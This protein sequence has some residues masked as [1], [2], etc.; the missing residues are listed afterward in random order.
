MQSL[1]RVAMHERVCVCN[2]T[3]CINAACVF[4][5]N[6]SMSCTR[7]FAFRGGCVMAPVRWNR[8]SLLRPPLKAHVRAW[9]RSTADTKN[10]QRYL[11]HVF[12]VHVYAADVFLKLTWL[13][14]V[15]MTL[16]NEG[17]INTKGKNYNNIDKT[18]AK[19]IP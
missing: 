11:V 18:L 12:S 9:W 8:P 5:F 15:S 2:I 14:F 7:A 19:K 16:N 6:R 17:P 10:I 1:V 13:Y 3:P 4:Y